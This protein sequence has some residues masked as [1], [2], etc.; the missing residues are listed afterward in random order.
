V[1]QQSV[2]DFGCKQQSRADQ[3]AYKPKQIDKFGCEQKSG[4]GG[5]ALR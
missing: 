1:P 5:I 3:F 4:V 2:D